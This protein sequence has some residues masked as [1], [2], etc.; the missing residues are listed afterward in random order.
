MR[1]L[2]I[3]QYSS[4]RWSFFQDV[5]KYTNLGFDSIGLWRSKVEDF[6]IE[7][8]ADLL[9]EMQMTVSSLSWAGGFTGSDGK[10]FKMAVADAIDAA[11]QAHLLGANKLILHPGTRNGHTESHATR[12]LKTAIAEIAPITRELGVQ[13][14]LQPN[15]TRENSLTFLDKTQQ[16]LNLFAE[17]SPSDLGI[18][19]DL[20]HVG[21]SNNFYHDLAHYKDRIGL[22]QLSDGRQRENEFVRCEFGNG[23]IPIQ[24]WLNLLAVNDYCGPF[25][26]KMHGYEF[27]N[28]NYENVLQSSE[29]YIENSLAT[30]QTQSL[31]N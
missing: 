9:F 24:N 5:I 11:Y 30:L 29:T 19:V 28:V 8:A 17:F 3:H 27:E 7:E 10:S 22:V 23:V 20:F 14:L 31:S 1:R 12:L 13:L 25:E 26:L 6:G 21:R 4:F 15:C 18:V 16:Y 2:S